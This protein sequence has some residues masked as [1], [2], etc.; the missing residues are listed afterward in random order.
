MFVTL[1]DL[2]D[3]V[4]IRVDDPI[5]VASDT[6]A[7]IER[8][9]GGSAANVAAMAARLGHPTRFLG[10][11]GDDAI[12]DVLVADLAADGVDVSHVRQGGRLGHDRRPR[13]PGRGTDDVDRSRARARELDR[14]SERWLDGAETLHVPMYSF[15]GE[16]LASTTGTVIGWA[17]EHDV[18][19]SIDV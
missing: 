16:P 17:R 3:D 11:V 19:V 7:T 15:V 8:R 18:A 6:A 5:N 1:G 9:R 2:V 4:V 10:K 12:G 13:R 14:P